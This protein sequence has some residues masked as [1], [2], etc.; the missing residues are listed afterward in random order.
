MAWYVRRGWGGYGG[1]FPRSRPRRA[2]GGIKSQSR[3]G[4]F[5]ESWWARR[6]I[7][8][9]ESF[10]VGGRLGRGRSYARQGQVLSIDIHK[11]SVA[12]SVQGS[13]RSP[14]KVTIDVKP[15]SADAWRRVARKLSQQAIFS[16]KLMAGEM[17]QEF[18]DVFQSARLSLFPQRAKDLTTDCSC[19]DWSNP[20]KHIA[21]VYYLIGEQFDKDPFLLLR[22]RGIERKELLDLVGLPDRARLAG[23][24][25]TISVPTER[26]LRLV[27]K[28]KQ[29]RTVSKGDGLDNRR[30]DTKQASAQPR[31]ASPGTKADEPAS[32]GQQVPSDPQIFWQGGQAASAG[33]GPVQ[34]PSRSAGLVKRLGNIPFWRGQDRFIEWME[35]VYSDA[36]P[37]GMDVFLGRI[38][39]GDP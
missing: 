13:Q 21:A 22:L 1:F 23:G 19:P 14:Y 18:E 30:R 11:G 39:D 27:D 6:W 15:L 3:R 2:K 4:S 28:G 25:K 5:G 24:A 37:V 29:R 12:A 31:S 16:A 33:F 34:V 10:D 38:T 20:C 35:R 7:E 17:P 8:V 32:A 26:S 9:L 36:S